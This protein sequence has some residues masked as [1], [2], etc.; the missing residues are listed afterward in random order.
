MAQ[1]SLACPQG[2]G[3]EKERGLDSLGF[4]LAIKP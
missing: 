4:G 2:V 3:L 1:L